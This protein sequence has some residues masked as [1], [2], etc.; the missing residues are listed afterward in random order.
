MSFR[1]FTEEQRR[2]AVRRYTAGE[3][4][5]A[6]AAEIGCSEP[7]VS[8]WVRKAGG[9]QALRGYR[10]RRVSERDRQGLGPT[11]LDMFD[12]GMCMNEIRRATGLPW[13]SVWSYVRA[14]RSAVAVRKNAGHYSSETQDE[15]L[16][17]VRSGLSRRAVA[18]KIGCHRNTIESWCAKYGPRRSTRKG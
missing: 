16:E 8:V 18:E 15:A 2:E 9:W 1:V 3:K 6:I 12:R 4:V 17:L 11:I 10:A 13:R 14:N 7:S 5:A